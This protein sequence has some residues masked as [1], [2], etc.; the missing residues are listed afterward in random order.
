MT[1]SID[2]ITADASKLKNRALAYAF[3]SSPYIITV[4]AGSKASDDF[5]YN[6]SWRWGFGCFAI[7]LPFVAAPLFV[8]L[9]LN[10]RKAE[11]QGLVLRGKSERKLLPNIW[12]Y[13][14]EFDGET[15]TF[16]EKDIPKY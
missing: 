7:I 5:Y 2:V 8:V 3:T 16:L 11:K 14:L 4:F 12:Y 13:I 15:S 9:K 10:L 6:T 1:H